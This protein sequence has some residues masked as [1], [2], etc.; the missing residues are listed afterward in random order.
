MIL[1]RRFHMV[2]SGRIA[3]IKGRDAWAGEVRGDGSGGGDG[4]GSGRRGL[5]TKSWDIF[6]VSTCFRR[7]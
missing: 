1:P 4:G 7:R 2:H 5:A 3:G 6:V